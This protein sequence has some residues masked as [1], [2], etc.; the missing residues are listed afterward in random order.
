MSSIATTAQESRTQ[1]LN[2]NPVIINEVRAV[3]DAIQAAVVAGQLQVT[4]SNSP[5]TTPTSDPNNPG[6]AEAFFQVWQSLTTD[7]LAQLQMSTVISYFTDNG[8][9]MTQTVNTTTN[10]TFVWSIQW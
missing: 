1:A 2:T 9:S 5:M 8:Y 3:E 4:V 7:R 10:N 6:P